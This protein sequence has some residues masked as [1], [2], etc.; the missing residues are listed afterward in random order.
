MAKQSSTSKIKIKNQLNQQSS[1]QRSNT[2][3]IVEMMLVVTTPS[4]KQ[5]IGIQC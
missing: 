4:T 3:S 2:S 5:S 1:N